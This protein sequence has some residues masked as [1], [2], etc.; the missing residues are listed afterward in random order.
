MYEEN[1]FDSFLLTLVCFVDGFLL[2]DFKVGNAR[3]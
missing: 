3:R 1:M 2:I